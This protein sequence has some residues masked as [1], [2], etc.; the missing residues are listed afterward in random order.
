MLV[1]DADITPAWVGSGLVPMPATRTLLRAMRSRRA[2][3]GERDGDEK[4]A[5]LVLEAPWPGGRG[6][7]SR[8]GGPGARRDDEVRLPCPVPAV[9]ELGSVHFIAIGGI[10]MSGVA[11]LM[12]AAGVAV[13][14]SDAAGTPPSSR[15]FAEA[16]ARAW[17][18]HDAAT[19]GG[20]DTVVVSSAVREDNVEL[21][22]ARATGLRVLHRSQALAALLGD[23][24]RVA[25]AGANGKTTTTS[26]LTVALRRPGPTRRS[27][28]AGRSPVR[29]E[30]RT[31]TGGVF[32]VEADE[33]DGSFL[34]YRPH[35]ERR[36]ERPGR[37]PRL[38]RGRRARPRR[39]PEFVATM[40][41]GGLLV[42][43]ADDPG[44]A[45]LAEE[46]A[47]RGPSRVLTYGFTPARTSPSGEPAADGMGT[48]ATSSDPTASP[49][50]SGS[51]SPATTTCST[52]P[53]PRPRRP[54]PRGTTPTGSSRDSQP[55]RGATAL[56]GPR[57]RL[58]ASRSST[59]TPTTPLRSRPSSGPPPG[60]TPAGGSSSSS[61]H[62]CTPARETSRPSSP[63][64]CARRRGRPP[65]RLRGP[66]GPGPRRRLRAHRGAAPGGGP[67]SRCARTARDVA[68][69][70]RRAADS[71]DVVL[72]VGA[73]DVTALVPGSS[74][75]GGGAPV[76]S[77]STTR[78]GSRGP[79]RSSRPR[80]GSRRG[81]P[82]RGAPLRRARLGA[83]RRRASPP[84]AWVVLASPCS[85]SRSVPSRASPPG[86]R[87][88]PGARDVP[89]GHAARPG[90]HR[91]RRG[92][93]GRPT[94]RRPR[95]GAPRASRGPSPST[96]TAAEAGARRPGSGRSAHLVDI[97][98]VAFETVARRRPGC[99]SSVRTTGVG[100]RRRGSHARSSMLSCSP[101]TS[102]NGSTTSGQRRRH[103]QLRVG[104][105]RRG[106][107]DR[108]AARGQGGDRPG[109]LLRRVAPRAVID[110]RRARRRTRPVDPAGLPTAPGHGRG[111]GPGADRGA[112]P[113]SRPTRRVFGAAPDG[114]EVADETWRDQAAY[115]C[116]R[117]A[118]SQTA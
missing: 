64:P 114:A 90:R 10:G 47:R 112:A 9:G 52:R 59:T 49:G 41:D 92:P 6:R 98:G 51:P 32:V 68:A 118:S 104:A 78:R 57:A 79:R 103:P 36:D 66:G 3:S 48:P 91:S 39:I 113:Y 33:S 25:V 19:S 22:A 70:R 85:P 93:G 26:M 73:G 76:S 75:P 29:D 102:P 12:L 115:V 81:P 65:R 108:G 2:R 63:L 71:G 101:P 55:T 42:A 69:T 18:G 86:T 17:T 80:T 45:E 96:S 94:V 82:G 54:R 110:V 99:P 21:A 24:P 35:V 15:P 31:G 5:D 60:C 7:R 105:R 23:R 46:A 37:P 27:R 13:S 95:L 107:G 84:A 16:G 28:P 77:R 50:R 111:G 30:R 100:L 1:E 83:P 67:R 117:R 58:A 62:T 34:V 72:T 89:V 116:R 11:R 38:L 20:A 97:E 88:G 44:S 8:R 61:S 14:G 53:P 109:V 43:C 40:P 56:R 4:L 74:S 106:L 87:R